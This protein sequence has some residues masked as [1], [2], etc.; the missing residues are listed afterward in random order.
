MK[1]LVS[2][3]GGRRPCLLGGCGG[4]APPAVA[5]RIR[6]G[7]ARRDVDDKHET[8]THFGNLF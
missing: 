5:Q 4:A 8:L 3:H 2:R 6:F 1:V 7:A